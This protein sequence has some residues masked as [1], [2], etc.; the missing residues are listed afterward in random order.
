MVT[1]RK[2][3]IVVDTVSLLPAV[4]VHA[5]NIQGRDGAKLALAKLLGN[6]SRLQLTCA[7]VG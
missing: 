3:H 6:F 5:A 7:G 4:A 1:G 2:R